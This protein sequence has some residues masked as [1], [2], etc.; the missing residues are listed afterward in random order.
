MSAPSSYDIESAILCRYRAGWATK[1]RMVP[2]EGGVPENLWLAEVAGGLRGGGTGFD[3]RH[4]SCGQACEGLAEEPVSDSL[5]SRTQVIPS[6]QTEITL[7][8]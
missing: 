3:D 6:P 8:A 2:W 5:D 7:P 4:W 1:R